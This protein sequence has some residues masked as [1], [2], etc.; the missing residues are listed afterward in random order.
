[1]N[2]IEQLHL[3][4]IN[5]YES[6]MIKHSAIYVIDKEKAA[7]KSAEITEQTAIEYSTWLFE[8]CEYNKY[9]KLMYG[10]KPYG[11]GDFISD[12]DMFQEFLKTK[13]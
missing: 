4:A 6:E 7:S 9:R 2:K 11:S 5:E 1:M 13:Q 3:D 8:W 12:K 10:V